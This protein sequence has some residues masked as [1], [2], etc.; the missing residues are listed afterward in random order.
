MVV[1]RT[2]TGEM[3]VWA[4][5]FVCDAEVCIVDGVE[6]YVLLHTQHIYAPAQMVPNTGSADVQFTRSDGAVFSYQWVDPDEVPIPRLHSWIDRDMASAWLQEMVR[7]AKQ[8]VLCEAC[9]AL[10]QAS[11]GYYEPGEYAYCAR[12]CHW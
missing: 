1:N 11:E 9:G 5:G 12:C 2:E 7:W 6:G 4:T 8:E 3:V 10:F